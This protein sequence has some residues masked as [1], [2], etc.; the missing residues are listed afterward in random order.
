MIEFAL[1]FA[2]GFLTA[3]I[4][5]LLVAPAV[6]KRI[7]RFAEDRLKATMPLSPQEVR[8][9]KDAARAGYA[10]ENARTSQA[11]KRERDKAV[12]LMVSNGTML[13][14]AQRLTGENA[15]LHT[16]IADMNVEAADL[17]SSIRQFEQRI[18]RLKSTLTAVESDNEGKT[19]EIRTL[20]RQ[21]DHISADVDGM[22]IDLATRDTEVENLKSRITGLR[23]E[24]ESLREEIK[25]EGAR[26]REMEVR[27]GR[28][29][30]RIRQLE[31]RLSKEIAANADKDNV[32]ERRT[33]EVER[34]RAKNKETG[35]ELRD[36]SRALRTA[37]VTQLPRKEKKLPE[38]PGL[39]AVSPS[40][41]DIPTLSEDAR[42]RATAVS[43]RLSNS[44]T[45]AHDDA[46]RL[47]IAGIAA[48]MI[49][50]TAASEGV[51]S[52]IHSILSAEAVSSTRSGRDSLAGRARALLPPNEA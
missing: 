20:L 19:K 30:V 40:A 15:E 25:A 10:A 52:P 23:D 39:A 5:G 17:R 48:T 9:Q 11:L 6:H 28:E 26:A 31:T 29:E 45:S 44:R 37:G 18:E 8:A 38:P 49:A 22:R 21:L 32:I 13:Q 12:A 24:R 50:V 16:Q 3:A 41:I 4:F 35:L 36:A 46:L 27:L 47:E 7:I 1:L 33:A 51:A 2:L 42:N 43:E 14:E 34:L